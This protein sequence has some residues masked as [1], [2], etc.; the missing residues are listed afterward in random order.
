MDE[1]RT[2]DLVFYAFDL[3]F[4]D[5]TSTMELPLIE[6]KALLKKTIDKTDIQFSESFEIDGAAMYKHACTIGLERRRLES[7]RQPLQLG[8][9]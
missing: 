7:A 2:G 4:L 3:L 8:S 1:G 5:G 9:R 6:R